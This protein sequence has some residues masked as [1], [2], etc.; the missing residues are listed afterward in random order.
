MD[1]K[2]K[3]SAKKHSKEFLHSLPCCCLVGIQ[4]SSQNKPV[5]SGYAPVNGVKMYYEV[6]RPGQAAGFITWSIQ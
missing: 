3:E 5:Q 2:N 4:S 6:Y 1:N